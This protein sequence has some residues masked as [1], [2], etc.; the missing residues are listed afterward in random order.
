MKKDKFKSSFKFAFGA[1]PF[2][3]L[4]T[5]AVVVLRILLK[6][7]HGEVMISRLDLIL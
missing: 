5:L 1:E 3:R 4:A 2:L 7:S 6:H